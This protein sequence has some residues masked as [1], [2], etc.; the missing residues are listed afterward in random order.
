MLECAGHNCAVSGGCHNLC[1]FSLFLKCFF[2]LR[3]ATLFFAF[4]GLALVPQSTL[5]GLGVGSAVALLFVL[6]VNLS[7]T[8]IMLLSFPSF[9]FSPLSQ[10]GPCWSWVPARVAAWW[11]THEESSLAVEQSFFYRLGKR[12][13]GS[14]WVALAVVLGVSAFCLLFA[15][16]AF[17]FQQYISNS[18]QL[19]LPRGDPYTDAVLTMQDDFGGG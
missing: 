5:R 13:T 6:A 2:L 17:T 12:I 16:P 8:P 4:A 19:A 15:Y 9:F 3:K 14:V 7:L 18:Y 11:N 1:S 10:P